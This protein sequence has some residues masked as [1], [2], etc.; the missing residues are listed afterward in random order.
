M[1]GRILDGRYQILEKLGE[2]GFG[3]TFLA[4]DIKRPG[5]PRCVVKL[6]KPKSNDPRTLKVGEKLFK[7][8][9]E[10]LERLGNHDQIP[11]LLAHFQENQEFYLVQEYIEGYDLSRELVPGTQLSEVYVTKLLQDTLDVLVFVHQQNIIHRDLKPSNIRRRESDKKI[12]LIDFGAVKEITT[13]VVNAQGQTAIVTQIGTPGYM[14]VEQAI[15]Q[16]TLSSDIY[17]LGV[18]AI[19]ALTG[20]NPSPRIGGGLPTDPQTKEIVW[21]DRTQVSPKLANIIDKM[22]RRENDQRYQSAEEA[23]QAIKGLSVKPPT[24]RSWKVW[25][26]VGVV[27]A[28]APLILWILYQIVNPKPKLLLY[29]NPS[30]GITIKYP[31]NW[32]PQEGGDSYEYEITFISTNHNPVNTCYLE[33]HIN[34]T[35]EKRSLDESKNIAIQNIKKIKSN[36]QPTEDSQPSTTLS[37]FRA[38]K[39]IYTR[40]EEQ[41]K[42]KVMEIGTVR[43]GKAYYI[44]YI[45]EVT[46]YSKYLSLAEDMINSFEIREKSNIPPTLD[47]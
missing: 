2:G 13:Q 30:K 10:T 41:C 11:R 47:K 27:V 8:E 23:L 15:G 7:R 34:I 25:L 37:N 21:R 5:N 20:I 46:E 26:G 3:L 24:S 38:Y 39:L 9:A 36:S 43:D 32:K 12:L 14:P 33:I 31:E 1:I 45:A 6:F 42:Y 17:A 19:Q 40:Q 18:I 16:P 44:T 28:I 29:N 4:V 22:V 35:Q